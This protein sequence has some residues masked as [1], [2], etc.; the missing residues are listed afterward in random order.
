MKSTLSGKPS[1]I[2]PSRS[3]KPGSGSWKPSRK[4]RKAL[5]DDI[6]IALDLAVAG[7]QKALAAALTAQGGR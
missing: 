5:R 3:T 1:T 7:I 4:A 2:V 6:A